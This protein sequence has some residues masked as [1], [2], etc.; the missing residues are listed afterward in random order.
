MSEFERHELVP[1]LTRELAQAGISHPTSSQQSVFAFAP[2]GH[3]APS[4]VQ[5]AAGKTLGF[6]LAM[7]PQCPHAHLVP[8]MAT[9]KQKRPAK[10]GD[11]TNRA[12]TSPAR[13]SDDDSRASHARALGQGDTAR[14]S[15]AA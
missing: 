4:R 12:L 10:R 14:S 8:A 3:D 11:K 9:T 5:E 6:G 15:A 1:V 7:S 13:F 2:Q